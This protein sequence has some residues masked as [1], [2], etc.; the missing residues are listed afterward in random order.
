MNFMKFSNDNNIY[1]IRVKN[2]INFHLNLN[3]NKI[4][5]KIHLKMKQILIFKMFQT[6]DKSQHPLK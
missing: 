3:V 2:E 4:F 5:N 6:R 1:K